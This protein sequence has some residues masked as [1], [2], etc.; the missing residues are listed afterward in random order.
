MKLIDGENDGVHV[1]LSLFKHVLC[2]TNDHEKPA[3]AT[4]HFHQCSYFTFYGNLHVTQR[5]IK[6]L[7]T[8]TLLL[9]L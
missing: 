2:F 8:D 4:V 1:E 6:V 9:G 3:N 5:Q 7:G